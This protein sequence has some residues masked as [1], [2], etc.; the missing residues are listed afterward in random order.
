MLVFNQNVFDE[1]LV[2]TGAYYS[3]SL[4]DTLLATPDFVL[5][6]AQATQVGGTSPR[7]VVHLEQSC[8]DRD[9]YT[10]AAPLI[11]SAISNNT[12]VAA[13]SSS[14]TLGFARLRVVL[15]GTTPTARIRISGTGRSY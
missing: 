14:E 15:Q 3:S 12:V 2:G 7:L 10:P 4:L 9:W 1:I 5:L 6:I 8:N 11:D 13:Q